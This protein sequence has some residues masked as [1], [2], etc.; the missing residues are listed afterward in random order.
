MSSNY[1][2][3]NAVLMLE[4]GTVF[5]GYGIGKKGINGGEICFNTQIGRAH[6]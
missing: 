3:K 4:D 5:L 2:N 1:K 6:V